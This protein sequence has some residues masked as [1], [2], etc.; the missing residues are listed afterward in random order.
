[1]EHHNG[2]V[3]DLK[4]LI[5]ILS[6]GKEGYKSAIEITKD[7]ELKALL[8]KLAVQ[9]E[10]YAEELKAHLEQHYVESDHESDGVL[11][12]LR[13]IWID[14]RQVKKREAAIGDASFYANPVELLQKQVTG[15]QKALSQIQGYHERLQAMG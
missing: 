13:R 11:G 6:N 1:M 3:S 10:L 2:I 7:Q 8:L 5:N 4:E 14:I 15:L 9:Q 12:A